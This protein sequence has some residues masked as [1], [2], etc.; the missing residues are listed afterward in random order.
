MKFGDDGRLYAINP[1]FGF[2]GVAPGTN[3]RLEPERDAHDGR[4]TRCSPTPRSPTTATCGGR[5]SPT[6][7]PRT[8]PTGRA[9]RGRPTSGRPRRA[10]ELPVLRARVAVPVD[11]PRVAGPE[12]R[13]DLGV[14][15]RRPPRHHRAARVRVARLAARR[16]RRRDDGFRE[17]RRRRR[18]ARRAA[19]RPVRDAAVLRLQHG[20]LL[21]ALAEHD[22]AHRRGVAAPR[23]TAS[24]GSART[25]TA[26]SSGPA[27]ARTP[28]CS[29]GSAAG[30]TATPSGADTA[31]G[32]V[33]RPSDLD[34]R[35]ARRAATPT[36]PPRSRSTPTSGSASS[37]ASASTSPSSATACPRARR[38]ARRAR[39]TPR[40]TGVTAAVRSIR[41]V[42]RRL[43]YPRRATGPSAGEGRAEGPHE[44]HGVRADPDRGR[45]A[46]KVAK[47]ARAIAGVVAAD[48]VAGPYD[49]IVQAECRLARRPRQARRLA[50][51]RRSTASP[52]PSPAPSSTSDRTWRRRPS[53]GRSHA[54]AGCVLRVSADGR[55]A[56]RGGRGGRARGR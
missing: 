52:A 8:S 34:A 11:R 20:R 31:I 45:T 13:A 30:S 40:L 38:A 35:R 14:P 36:S 22:R 25:P 47:A 28:G 23:S 41:R 15:L 55:R 49:V 44:R 50:R 21:R 42:E 37:P 10:P 48:N 46:A 54:D 56:R 16:V 3:E 7:R 2:F 29:S 24:T 32:V 17:D 39:G 1:E 27:S 43:Q 6:S 18:R 26:S 9:S 12:G 4:A 53:S 5:T 51:S 19:P 33:P